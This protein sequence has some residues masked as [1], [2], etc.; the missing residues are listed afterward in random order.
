[1]KVK[2]EAQVFSHSV[3][4]G[5]FTYVTLQGLPSTALGTAEVLFKFNSIFD[6]CNSI[7]FRDSKISRR[8]LTASSPHLK[9][10]EDGIRFVQLIKVVN[11]ATGE[12][13]ENKL[14][15]LKGW[16]ITSKAVSNLWHKLNEEH[17]VTFLVTRQLNQDP[18]E[19]FFG[20]IRQQGGNSDNPTPNQF[21]SAYPK[22]FHTNLLTVSAASCEQD[23]NELLAQLS[24]IRELPEVPVLEKPLKIASTDYSNEQV[25]NRV[26]KDNA[27]AY[28]AG[29]LLRKTY[30]KHKC[31]K[32]SVLSNNN[33]MENQNVI[34]FKAYESS[35]TF[36][37]L[38]VPSADMFAY[39]KQLE[40]AFMEYFSISRLKININGLFII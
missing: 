22:L 19:N 3:S 26:F 4:A 40:D 30:S 9:E 39:A 15:C 35:S 33:G 29:Y 11:G 13:H 25:E 14:R 18:L 12:D 38:V 24:D 2:L 20:S 17:D 10:M 31:E 8:P 7:S 36:S 5:I 6:C 34:M 37:G 28:V 23:E 21:K 27:M 32:C 1:M 16:C